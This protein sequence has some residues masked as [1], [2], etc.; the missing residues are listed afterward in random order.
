MT[1]I[2]SFP[3]TRVVYR[4]AAAGANIRVWSASPVVWSP[5]GRRAVPS[6]AAPPPTEGRAT[7]NELHIRP[8]LSSPGQTSR[9]PVPAGPPESRQLMRLAAHP[10]QR[11]TH[12]PFAPTILRVG[13]PVDSR[14]SGLHTRWSTGA[15][16][17]AAWRAFSLA[18]H[19]RVCRSSMEDRG[20]TVDCLSSNYQLT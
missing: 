5:D 10:T 15:P 6:S 19:P 11:H 4:I 7:G 8:L 18:L 20:L 13:N 14:A 12:P 17:P 1:G 9:V 16:D 3:C 2:V